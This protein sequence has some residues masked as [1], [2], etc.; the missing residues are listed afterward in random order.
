[1][2]NQPKGGAPSFDFNLDPAD[3]AQLSKM[4]HFL[5]TWE[6]SQ[7]VLN[8]VAQRY[9]KDGI[10]ILRGRTLRR[11]RGNGVE[12]RLIADAD[13]LAA[14]LKNDFALDLPEAHGLW[15]KIAARHEVIMA[16][17]VATENGAKSAT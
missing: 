9:T 13:D 11:L 12:D 10:V 5:Q 1:L 4:C 3:E 15:P 8:A 14:T 2:N 16:Q 17:K 7:F 6:Q